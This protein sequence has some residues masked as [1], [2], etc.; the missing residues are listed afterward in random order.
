[1][2]QILDLDPRTHAQKLATHHAWMAF[3]LKQSRSSPPLGH[4]IPMQKW[5]ASSQHHISA[6]TP[7]L[8]MIF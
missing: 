3:P 4:P 1:M 8:W 5:S 6:H 7:P 2:V